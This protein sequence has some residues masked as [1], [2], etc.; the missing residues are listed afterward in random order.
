MNTNVNNNNDFPMPT[1]DDL[2]SVGSAPSQEERTT[3]TTNNIDTTNDASTFPI[4]GVE[5]VAK[6]APL[7]EQSRST[8]SKQRV[9]FDNKVITLLFDAAFDEE[10]M[11]KKGLQKDKSSTN[12][13]RWNR[14]AIKVCQATSRSCAG[15]GCR[16]KASQLVSTV[17]A[18]IKAKAEGIPGTL[19]ERAYHAIVRVINQKKE[20]EANKGKSKEDDLTEQGNAL[21]RRSAMKLFHGQ[22]AR[23]SGSPVTL[24]EAG[25]TSVADSDEEGATPVPPPAKKPTRSPTARSSD[26]LAMLVEL[27]KSEIEKKEK[28]EER[29]FQFRRMQFEEETRI[30]NAE[31]QLKLK[32]SD[33]LIKSF[34]E[35][36][37]KMN[38]RLNRDEGDTANRKKKR[39]RRSNREDPPL[40]QDSEDSDNHSNRNST[41]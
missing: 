11:V 36:L 18:H 23:V 26:C 13:V 12:G 20:A 37:L 3:T 40:T 27:R 22:A 21:R 4:D 30:R 2:S 28:S 38:A 17:E 5:A 31:L 1:D 29:E 41:E 9:H 8:A 32:A 25:P 7:A 33:D 16:E 15:R 35:E 6:E 19:D 14:I 10:V 39:A 34:K 24:T